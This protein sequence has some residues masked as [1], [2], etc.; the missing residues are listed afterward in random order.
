MAE[1]VRRSWL[2]GV[3]DGAH[4]LGTDGTIPCYYIRRDKVRALAKSF[5]DMHN[6]DEVW[7][8]HDTKWTQQA[9]ELSPSEFVEYVRKVGKRI[10]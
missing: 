6:F 8:L 2:L 3:K 7:E 9:C 5:Q 1:G 10:I 4:P